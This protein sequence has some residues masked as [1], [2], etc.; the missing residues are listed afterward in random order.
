M[1]HSAGAGDTKNQ[2]TALRSCIAAKNRAKNGPDRIPHTA[3]FSRSTGISR[4]E[5]GALRRVKIDNTHLMHSV[6]GSEGCRAAVSGQMEETGT[7]TVRWDDAEK[8][9]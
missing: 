7:R 3:H 8:G 5:G 2:R 9:L 6:C 4:N 1:L